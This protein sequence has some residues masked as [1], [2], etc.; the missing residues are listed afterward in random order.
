MDI[1]AQI[2]KCPTQN[3]RKRIATSKTKRCKQEPGPTCPK[4]G[5]P[6]SIATGNKFQQETDYTGRGDARLQISR[7]YNSISTTAKISIGKNWRFYYDRR[8]TRAGVSTQLVSRASGKDYFFRLIGTNWLPDSDI[9]DTLIQL[10][11]GTGV[12]T[13]WRYYESASEDV[14]L[15]SA[16]GVLLSITDRAGRMT[17]LTYSDA[18][19]LPAI[20]PGA[21][22]LT[23]VT[24][25]YGH[26]LQLA[27]DSTGKLVTITDPANGVFQYGYDGLGNLGTVTSPD[28]R[29]RR[30]LYNEGANNA[31]PRRT[32]LL[33]GIVDEN[34]VRLAIYK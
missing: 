28:N 5:N 4:C 20:A 31:A 17:T 15:Y 2:H 26:S 9:A 19:T 22:Y 21:G 16:A 18:A 33:T 8:I 30:Y 29:V 24:D 13:G 27:Y 25:P 32:W 11:D 23:Q 6:I 3:C 7:F 14:E 10:K 34:K 1:L 12:T